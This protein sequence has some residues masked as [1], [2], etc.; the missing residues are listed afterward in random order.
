MQYTWCT[1]CTWCTDL[2]VCLTHLMYLVYFVHTPGNLLLMKNNSSQSTLY[3]C[4]QWK[5]CCIPIFRTR[6]QRVH[7]KETNLAKPKQSNSA[8]RPYIF[9]SLWFQL[10][11][12][13]HVTDLYEILSLKWFNWHLMIFSLHFALDK[14]RNTRVVWHL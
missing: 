13:N 8:N 12:G 7:T 14:I 6:G 2:P 3:L 11:C 10:S 5:D 1:E 4:R 9:Q